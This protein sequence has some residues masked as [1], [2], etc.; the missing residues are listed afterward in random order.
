M[1]RYGHGPLFFLNHP[2]QLGLILGLD[3]I[4]LP[5]NPSL[6]LNKFI[7]LATQL[8]VEEA[9][10]LVLDLDLLAEFFEVGEEFFHFGL[11]LVVL[12]LE[13]W[14]G[15]RGPVELGGHH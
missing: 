3:L 10:F 1:V 9:D 11:L 2:L 13:V 8:E 15:G 6:F 14:R 12:G 7:L 5:Q 4:P